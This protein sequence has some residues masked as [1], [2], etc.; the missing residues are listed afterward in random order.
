[1]TNSAL[2]KVLVGSLAEYFATV[3]AIRDRWTKEDRQRRR[4]SSGQSVTVWFRGLPDATLRLEPSL[5]RGRTNIKEALDDEDEIRTDFTNNGLQMMDGFRPADD[6][7]WYF[8]MR[9]YGAPTRLLDWTDGAA[10]ALYFACGDLATRTSNDAAV[11]V[12]DPMWLNNQVLGRDT[13]LLTSWAEVAPY[14]PTAF[15]SALSAQYPV[16]VDPPHVARRLAVQKGRFTIH[17]TQPD[18]LEALQVKAEEPLRLLKISIAR[19]AV[20]Q[21]R[22]DLETCG[23]TETTLFPDLEALGRELRRR[24]GP[25]R[26]RRRQIQKA[27]AAGSADETGPHSGP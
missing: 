20:A 8:L 9:H 3:F 27:T 18:G 23:I 17:G 16:A 2:E 21:V 19:K 12:L 4:L 10:I 15:E 5:Y 25:E 13:V 24:W 14:L 11:W 6:W 26:R 22:D 7:E 1:L